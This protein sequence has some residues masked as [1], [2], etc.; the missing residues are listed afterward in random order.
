MRPVPL[1]LQAGEETISILLG[2]RLAHT[3]N[4]PQVGLARRP[5]LHHRRELLV[6]EDHVDRHCLILRDHLPQFPEL[7]ERRELLRAQHLAVIDL[8][9]W[10]AWSPTAGLGGL[11]RLQVIDAEAPVRLRPEVHPPPVDAQHPMAAKKPVQ[12]L[13]GRATVPNRDLEESK[14][15]RMARSLA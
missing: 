5:S 9:A 10:L 7:D 11:D 1:G 8:A 3:I 6:R 4:P 15:D 13:L 2:A 14:S 12:L